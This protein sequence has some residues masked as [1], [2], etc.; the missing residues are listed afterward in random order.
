MSAAAADGTAAC[1]CAGALR[2][3]VRSASS[4]FGGASTPAERS[5]LC[6]LDSFVGRGPVKYFLRDG[7]TDHLVV[8]CTCAP[9]QCAATARSRGAVFCRVDAELSVGFQPQLRTS[10]RLRDD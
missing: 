10:V 7:C 3:R 9:M 2:G 5:L 8:V 6:D 4:V 1:V